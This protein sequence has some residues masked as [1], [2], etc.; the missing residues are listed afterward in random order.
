M[1]I[2]SFADHL[3]QHG[4]KNTLL[5]LGRRLIVKVTVQLI[6]RDRFRIDHLVFHLQTLYF[7]VVL[8]GNLF[9]FFFSMHAVK[10]VGK[11]LPSD[12]LARH[13]RSDKHVTMASHL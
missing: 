9:L 13:S 1:H 10:S 12:G 11:H 8:F 6:L 2:L 4:S 7:R 5:P 3:I